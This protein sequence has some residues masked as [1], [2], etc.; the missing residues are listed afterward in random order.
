[1]ESLILVESRTTSCLR[2]SGA[3][4]RESTGCQRADAEVR[5]VVAT[6]DWHPVGHVSASSH[7]GE[8]CDIVMEAEWSRCCGRTT[9]FRELRSGV[10]AR[11]GCEPHRS[12]RIQGTD[13]EIDSYSG[14]DAVIAD[15]LA[16]PAA[17][18]PQGG[19]HLCYGVSHRLLRE[20][21]R[22]TARL[23]YTVTGDGRVGSG[24]QSGD[25]D[26]AIREMAESGVRIVTSA[27]LL[28]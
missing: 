24:R 22:W 11:S 9:A 1:M 19:C 12:N 23:G 16:A 6:A 21:R 7:A 28:G 4:G 25:V 26:R 14:F 17:A 13:P 20:I 2:H 10:C 18:R 3:P 15:R 27:D 5:P 8:A